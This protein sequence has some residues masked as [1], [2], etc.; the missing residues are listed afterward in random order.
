[1]MRIRF[2]NS[3]WFVLSKNSDIL[4]I[5]IVSNKLGY[6]KDIKTSNDMMRLT[7]DFI[8]IQ[9]GEFNRTGYY[10]LAKLCL[11]PT[12]CEDHNPFWGNLSIIVTFG[13]VKGLWLRCF[14]STSWMSARGGGPWFMEKSQKTNISPP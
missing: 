6:H 14:S 7:P 1:M 8:S 5:S 12:R 10:N 2:F 3:W 11:K 13:Y 9:R 4:L